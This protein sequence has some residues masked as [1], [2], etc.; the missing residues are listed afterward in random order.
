MQTIVGI[1]GLGTVGKALYNQLL[2]LPNVTVKQ[3]AIR[4]TKKPRNV[5]PKLLTSDAF[6]IIEDP[7]VSVIIEAIDDA[8]AAAAYAK[9]T[10]KLGKTYI[11]ANKKMVAE[12]YDEL[13]LLELTFGGTLLVEATVGGAIPVIRT[14]KEH[15]AGEPILSI[16][17]IVNGSCNY[18]LTSMEKEGKSF[19][20]ALKVAQKLG[21]AE[22]DPTLDID[23]WD[24]YFKAQILAKKTFGVNA[25][26]QK[27]S[28]KGI[29]EVT[30][31][32]IKLATD[33]EQ[34]IRLVAEIKFV[35]NSYTISVAPTFVAN[36]DALY[37]IEWESNAI[38]IE[39]KYSGTLLLKGAGAGGNPTA[40]A[41]VGDLKKAIQ[42]N[43]W[44]RESQIAGIH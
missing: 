29:R 26:L 35:E 21:F 38:A 44:K 9:R 15:L 33:D 16:R 7:T 17:G 8:T 24:S 12:N 11:T 3:I 13:A 36:D 22:S 27:V 20:E 30:L 2:G 14:I 23:A 19:Q 41:M 31:E 4:D 40:A 32:D 37:N 25:K 42:D 39:G 34:R 28:W 5:A 18:I 10:L 1:I 6:E 43:I